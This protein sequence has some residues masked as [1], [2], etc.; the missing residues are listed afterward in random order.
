KDEAKAKGTGK[1]T[2][3]VAM[4]IQLPVPTIDIPVSM[5][6]LSTSKNLRIASSIRY[7]SPASIAA[8][9]NSFLVALEQALYFATIIA[10]A[11]GMHLMWRASEV[12]HYNLKLD[13]IALI[14]RGGCIIRSAFLDEIFRAYQ[15]NSGLRHLMLDQ[16]V[17]SLLKGSEQ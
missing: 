4:E 7:A 8:E 3:Q 15:Q 14:W 10:D 5:R 6:D 16:K 11:Q 13:K 12:F 2:S 9:T 1:W 17:A